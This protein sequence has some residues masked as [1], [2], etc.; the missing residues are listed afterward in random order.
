MLR[1]PVDFFI[2]VNQFTFH[3]RSPDVPALF[4]II[5]QGGITAPAER[6]G[7]AD[8]AALQQ[9]SACLQI[10][11]DERVGRL[12]KLTGEWIAPDYLAL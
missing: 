3:R 10:L 9:Q 12:N 5:D 8:S 7:M 11:Q 4:G 2:A 6:I 1:V